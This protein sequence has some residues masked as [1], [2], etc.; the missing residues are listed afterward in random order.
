MVMTELELKEKELEL[1]IYELAIRE[2]EANN[3]LVVA[4]LRFLSETKPKDV[5]NYFPKS[6]DKPCFQDIF[7]IFKETAGSLGCDIYWEIP[8]INEKTNQ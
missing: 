7:K 8:P 4:F 6:N 2:K 5:Y 3:T 1:K